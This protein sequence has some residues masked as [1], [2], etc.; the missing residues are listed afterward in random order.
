MGIVHMGPPKELILQLADR[1]KLRGFIETGT[2]KG[3]T[4]VWA[5]SY[6]DD[7]ITIEYS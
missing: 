1:Y 5:A 7:V 6:F 2:Y 4:A 3:N